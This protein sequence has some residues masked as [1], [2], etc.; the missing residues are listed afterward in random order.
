MAPRQEGCFVAKLLMEAESQ[1]LFKQK[2][3]AAISSLDLN[4]NLGCV[5]VIR[6]ER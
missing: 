1:L 2:T 4:S 5:V 6:L 3:L